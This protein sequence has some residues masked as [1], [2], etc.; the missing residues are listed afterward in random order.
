M[1]EDDEESYSRKTLSV[2]AINVQALI[3]VVLPK[4]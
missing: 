4:P 3:L 2:R 1:I